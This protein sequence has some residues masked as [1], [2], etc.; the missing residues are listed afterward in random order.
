MAYRLPSKQYKSEPDVPPPK[1]PGGNGGKRKPV[2]KGALTPAQG[3][4]YVFSVIGTTFLTLMLIIVIT[5][6]VVAVA[7]TVYI[8]QFADSMYDL[9]L[10]DVEL[11]YSSFLMA[12]D[13]E[14]E[15]YVE[16]LQLS[17]D[18]NRIWV[19]FEDIPQHVIDALVSTEDKRFYDHAGV[20]WHRTGGIVI[21]EMLMGGMDKMQGGS[22]ITQQLVRDITG[23]D[24]VNVGRKLR[25]I[26]RAL[27]L[28]QTH[29]KNDILESY[30][31]RVAFGP[32]VYGVGSAA[33]YYFD[34]DIQDVTPAEAAIMVALLPSPVVWNPYSN[35]RENRKWQG[36]VLF[37]MYDQGLLSYDQ[38]NAALDEQVQF[39]LPINPACRCP[40]PKDE[41]ED[42]YASRSLTRKCGGKGDYFGY[43]D[44]RWE[45][46]QGLQ[47]DGDDDDDLYYQNMERSDLLK[48]PFRWN[49][50]TVTHNWYIDAALKCITDEFAEA[51]GLSQSDAG[52]KLRSGGY[53]IYLSVDMEM[54]EKIEEVFRDELIIR[55]NRVGYSAGTP[56]RDT[57]QA[58]FV[59]MDYEGNIVA[60]AGGVGDKPGNSVF[61]RAVQAKRHVGSAVKPFA[62]Y[63]PAIDLG[64]ITYSTLLLDRSGLVPDPDRP[65]SM[66]SWPP[67]FGGSVS[68]QRQFTFR[69]MAVSS[70]TTAVR[71]LHMMGVKTSY[72]FVTTR[73]NMELNPSLHMDYSPLGN[74]AIEVRL[75]EVAG[76]YQIFG[77]GGVYYKPAFYSKIVDRQDNIILEKDVQGTQVIGSD[78]AYVVNRLMYDVV[79]RQGGTAYGQAAINGIDV[80]GKTGTANSMSDMTFAGL[81]PNYV[82]VV[83]LGYDD[84]R[85][86]DDYNQDRWRRP[87]AVWKEVMENVIP[88]DKP[89]SFKALA[90]AS[91]VLETNFC[92]ETGLRK[93]P[94]CPG[95]MG[96]YN[97][98]HLP[99]VC[100]HDGTADSLMPKYAVTPEAPTYI[101]N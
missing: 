78:S 86:M 81:T 1:K 92:Q 96:Y 18:E 38:Y 10:K 54:Q 64:V 66:K 2:R 88:T 3:V 32:T 74:G 4:K 83:R 61:N 59:L 79:N 21:K 20:D 90:D 13:P 35:P 43:I 46:A 62:V 48:D 24:E 94:G 25:E 67:N 71:T 40:D 6:C 91:G 68:G 30:L 44:E 84:S 73:L 42:D 60:L 69:A 57:M 87:G 70:N 34:K 53:R 5:V 93:G 98:N 85:A 16:I 22:T 99:P 52:D 49:E 7:L 23:D 14:V 80:V 11:N 27:S 58:A 28:E 15:D 39:R 19:D 45:E 8:T 41:D 101:V 55:K 72:D 65:G 33:R 51:Y 36:H 29:S 77:T 12:Y 95:S 31:N 100:P 50:Y 82:G 37:N 9:E 56:E 17:A 75:H 97:P 47:V 63:A 89:L 76:A 26:F